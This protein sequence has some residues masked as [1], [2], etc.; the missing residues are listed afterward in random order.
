MLCDAKGMCASHESED[1]KEDAE[2]AASGKHGDDGEEEVQ[3]VII[4]AALRRKALCKILMLYQ[5]QI[6]YAAVAKCQREEERGGVKLGQAPEKLFSVYRGLS[7]ILST[8]M[9]HGDDVVSEAVLT[10]FQEAS[11]A[12]I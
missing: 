6:L 4:D 9:Q 12:R 1:E 3:Q 8:D 7:A 11:I 5:H 2:P 10:A